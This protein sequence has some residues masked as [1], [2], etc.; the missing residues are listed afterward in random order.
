MTMNKRK[1]D[2]VAVMLVD[3]IS[4]GPRSHL[5]HE[6]VLYNPWHDSAHQ[7]WWLENGLIWPYTS[8]YTWRPFHISLYQVA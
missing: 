8:V 5:I 3:P 2:L 6:V 7:I 4:I 1:I